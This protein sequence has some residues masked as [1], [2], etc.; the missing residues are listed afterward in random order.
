MV[1]TNYFTKRPEAFAGPSIEATRIAQLLLDYVIARHSAPRHL[2]SDRGKNFLSKVVQAVWDLYQIRKCNTTAY[3][4]QTNGLT[5]KANATLMQSLS[6][7]TSANKKDWDVNLPALLFG[8]RVAPSPTTGES[9]FYLLYGREPVLPLNKVPASIDAYRSQLVQKLQLTHQVAKEQIQLSQQRMKDLY[10]RDSKPY[11]Y[12]LG[13][14]VWIFN[15]AI[16]PGFLKN[17][18]IDGTVLID[19]LNNFRLLISK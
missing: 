11:L 18:H 12:K 1:F 6:H 8:I 15:P 16:K 9:P 13:D 10:D 4:P 3:R 2:L 17:C 19:L 14:R 5:E 7:Y